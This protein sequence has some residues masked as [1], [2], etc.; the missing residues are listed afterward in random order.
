MKLSPVVRR[1]TRLRWDF[2]VVHTGQH[3]TRSMDSIF[4]EELRIPRPK[5]DLGVG[6]GTHAE[7]TGRMLIGVEKVIR[8]EK[9]DVVLVEGDTNTVLAG[10]L[11]AAKLHVKIG[12]IEAGL[13]SFDHRMPEELNRVVVDH[14]SDFLFAPTLGARR[15]LLREAVA[16]EKVFVTGNTIVDALEQNLRQSRKREV[17]A[18]TFSPHLLCTIHREENVDDAAR[19]KSIFKGLGLVYEKS[20]VKIVY[21]MHPRTKKRC[22]EYGIEPPR[23]TEVIEPLD[24]FSFLKLESDAQLVL[25]DSGGV[26]EEACI[27]RVPCVTVR[28]NTERPETVEVGANV[29]AGVDPEKIVDSSL[30]MLDRERNWPNPLGDGHAAEKI[31]AVLQ[32]HLQ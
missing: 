15:N 2:F 21:P 30:R 25:T 18:V 32:D 20:G 27:L 1:L 9:P 7:Q 29:I 8:E 4:L 19:L 26:Q 10:A 16:D 6:S 11:S 22:R 5:Y 31:V 3:Y 14:V 23:G 28:E 13:R 24:Y 12:H 17:R